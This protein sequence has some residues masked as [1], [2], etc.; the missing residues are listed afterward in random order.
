MLANSRDGRRAVVQKTSVLK[1]GRLGDDAHNLMFDLASRVR[2]RIR[3]TADG[4]PGRR[5]RSKS[6]L[7]SASGFGKPYGKITG[8][9]GR[10][11]RPA[12][13]QNVMD[14]LVG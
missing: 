7:S 6:G 1:P 14:R 12:G 11:E 2:P 5:R 3:L 8:P 10:F 4:S 9:L 13:L